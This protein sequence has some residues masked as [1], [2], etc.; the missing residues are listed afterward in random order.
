MISVKT[1][2]YLLLKKVPFKK[3]KSTHLS[4][5]IETLNPYQNQNES[6]VHLHVLLFTDKSNMGHP[7]GMPHDRLKNKFFTQNR[8]GYARPQAREVQRS[9]LY[10]YYI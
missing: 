5:S 2:W 7:S 3:M 4:L 9:R 8:K 1:P 6:E 10:I